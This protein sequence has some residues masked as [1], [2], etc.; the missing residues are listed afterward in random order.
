MVFYDVRILPVD[1]EGTMDILLRPCVVFPLSGLGT[2]VSGTPD[3]IA[4]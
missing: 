1:F 4:C 2:A 3:S